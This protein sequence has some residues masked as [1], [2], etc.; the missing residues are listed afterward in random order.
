MALNNIVM[1]IVPSWLTAQYN[2]YLLAV[3]D[4]IKLLTMTDSHLDNS[5]FHG[6]AEINILGLTNQ[7]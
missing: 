7:S 2:I 4:Q 6:D 1:L 3:A 5:R